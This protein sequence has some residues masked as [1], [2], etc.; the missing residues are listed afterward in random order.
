MST[1]E[2]QFEFAGF[3]FPKYVWTLPPIIL[4]LRDN[5]K[6]RLEHYREKNLNWRNPVFGP[7]YHAPRPEDAGKGQGFYL[8][9]D[10]MPGL[11]WR[12]CDEIVSVEHTGWFCDEYQDSKIRG[13]VMRLPKNRGFLAGW[14]MGEGMASEVYGRIYETEEDAAYAADSM[15]E[16]VAEKEREYRS[17]NE[18]ETE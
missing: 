4:V 6:L 1:L 16:N 5:A 2:K 11:R 15:A 17:E 9:S 14:S 10:G 13:L 18:E 8:E 7:Y 12:W 3:S